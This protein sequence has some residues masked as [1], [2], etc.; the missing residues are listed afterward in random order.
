MQTDIEYNDK[1]Y[2]VY[3]DITLGSHGDYFNPPEPPEIY[4]HSVVDEDGN[5]VQDYN[6][7]MYAHEEIYY[8]LNDGYFD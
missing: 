1:K 3:F 2:D 8:R 5:E 4:I 6:I 7:I